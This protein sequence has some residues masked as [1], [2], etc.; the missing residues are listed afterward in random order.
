MFFAAGA[1]RNRDLRARNAVWTRI[2]NT[3]DLDIKLQ[4]TGSQGPAELTLP[5]RTTSLVK[6]G[7]ADPAAP[8]ELPY[9]ATNFLIAPEEALPVTLEIPK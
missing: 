9:A 5:A 3:C 6:I 8:V 2:E 7:V 1:G 4:R